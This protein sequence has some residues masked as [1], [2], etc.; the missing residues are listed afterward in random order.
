M[1]TKLIFISFIV[2]VYGFAGHT[3]TKP[4]D[5][6]KMDKIQGLNKDDPTHYSWYI[7]AKHRKQENNR[8]WYV[9]RG[10]LPPLGGGSIG[11]TGGGTMGGHHAGMTFNPRIMGYGSVYDPLVAIIKQ[12]LL[13]VGITSNKPYDTE[14]GV[15]FFQETNTYPKTSVEFFNYQNR[16]SSD[17]FKE[18]LAYIRSRAPIT[19]TARLTRLFTLNLSIPDPKAQFL[20][21]MAFDELVIYVADRMNAALL[22]GAT[23]GLKIPALFRRLNDFNGILRQVFAFDSRVRISG[24]IPDTV[25][26]KI[27]G[28]WVNGVK[29]VSRKLIQTPP[30]ARVIYPA[31]R[32]IRENEDILSRDPAAHS[33]ILKQVIIQLLNTARREGSINNLLSAMNRTMNMRGGAREANTFENM[34][35]GLTPR[36]DRV[37]QIFLLDLCFQSN[38]ASLKEFASRNAAEVLF[39]TLDFKSPTSEEL[40]QLILLVDKLTGYRRSPVAAA[41]AADDAPEEA[42]ARGGDERAAREEEL[43]RGAAE[44]RANF[45]RARA[46]IAAGFVPR[47]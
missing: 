24:S 37:L 10:Y 22:P 30:T 12:H 31:D 17:F 21:Q 14:T 45:A 15:L 4:T 8:Q 13:D 34:I 47:I 6:L 18:C 38:V 20:N 25:M 41:A 39:N 16:I 1:I 40:I 32:N 19:D 26:S 33:K 5:R 28:I 11:A 43:R 35:K 44:R 3:T 7:E 42:A 27:I 9:D 29:E 23:A 46:G 36:K 2:L